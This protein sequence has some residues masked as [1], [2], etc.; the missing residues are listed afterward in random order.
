LTVEDLD[1]I[2]RT[3]TPNGAAA[4]MADEEHTAVLAYVL[5]Q[6]GYETGATT[7]RAGSPQMKQARLRFGI[8]KDMASAPPPLRVAGDAGAVPMNSAGPS[9]DELNRATESTRDWL[10]HTHDYSGARYV[11]LEKIHRQ[12]AGQLRPVCVFQV[13]GESNFQTGPIVYQGTMYITTARDTVALDATNC[14]PKWRHSWAPHDR[15]VWQTNRGVAIKDGYLVRGTADEYLL[16]LNAVTGAL[17][18]AQ[19]KRRH[20]DVRSEFFPMDA[21]N[22]PRHRRRPFR[23]NRQGGFG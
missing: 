6:N 16:A 13:G 5:Q 1:F 4:K 22:G 10:Y 15:E 20:D 2:I 7:L 12:N 9:Q 23:R 21:G 19:E 17:V 8:A 11:A 3:T 18:W 14:R